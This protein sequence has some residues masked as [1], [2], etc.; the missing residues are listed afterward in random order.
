[1]GKAQADPAVL[2]KQGEELHKQCVDSA[3]TLKY[4]N[5]TLRGLN[6]WVPHVDSTL[7]GLLKSMEEVGQPVTQLEVNQIDADQA[8]SVTIPDPT[9]LVPLLDSL[10]VMIP[11]CP[12]SRREFPHTPT[13]PDVSYHLG[14]FAASEFKASRGGSQRNRPPKTGF[15]RFD[16]EN[17]KW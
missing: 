12:A 5:E 14:T 4:I 7:Q 3:S 6:S 11:N 8:L 16:G 15:L 9:A 13:E 10:K 17:P 1:M 2:K